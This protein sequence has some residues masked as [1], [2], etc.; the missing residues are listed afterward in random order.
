MSAV[1]IYAFQY[2]S[3]WFTVEYSVHQGVCWHQTLL[4]RAWTGCWKELSAQA[5]MEYHL[6]CT[7]I[8]NLFTT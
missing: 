7:H 5:L 3:A 1:F 6:V 8:Q 4:A 2:Q